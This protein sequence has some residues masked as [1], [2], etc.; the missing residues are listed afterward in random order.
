MRCQWQTSTSERRPAAV[1][2][3]AAIALLLAGCATTATVNKGQATGRSTDTNEK[4]EDIA[5]Q[6]AVDIGVLRKNPPPVLVNA[7]QAPY[8][9][10]GLG[11]CTSLRQAIL[12]LNR[13]LGPD[14]DDLDDKGNP[15]PE[16]LAAAGAQSIINAFIPFRGLV[17]EASGAAEA[18][19][20]LQLMVAA[21]MARRGYLKGVAHQRGCRGY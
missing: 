15:L 13:V 7:Q 18:D 3:L 12:S 1:G 14:V 20:R 9:L 17:R 5:A 2:A 8:S 10:S 16:R 4:A 6:P 19:R 11:N 21:A